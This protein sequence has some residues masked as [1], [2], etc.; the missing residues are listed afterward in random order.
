MTDCTFQQEPRLEAASTKL[1]SLSGS[2]LPG[3]LMRDALV[4]GLL[5][6][7][8]CRSDQPVRLTRAHVTG[9]AD[10]SDMSISGA[11]AL[12]ADSLIVERD[13]LCRD[14]TIHG[15]LLTWSARIGGTPVLVRRSTHPLTRR[16]L[17][18]RTTVARRERRTLL[19]T[20]RSTPQ[21]PQR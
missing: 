9:T 10:L 6:L 20:H 13:L 19:R 8:G 18:R 12:H 2:R 7:T 5:H 16:T 1:V 11:P 15:E 3:E 14:A 4:D 17:P 21:Q